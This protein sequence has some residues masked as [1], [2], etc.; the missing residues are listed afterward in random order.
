LAWDG[1]LVVVFLVD[2][3]KNNWPNYV[4]IIRGWEKKKNTTI[5]VQI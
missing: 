2:L 4:A 5:H 1:G 3:G